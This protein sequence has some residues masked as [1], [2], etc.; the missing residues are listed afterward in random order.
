MIAAIVLVMGTIGVISWV[1]LIALITGVPV[2]AYPLRWVAAWWLR[3]PVAV[4]V[5]VLL[6]IML[7]RPAFGFARDLLAFVFPSLR[8]EPQQHWP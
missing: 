3:H 6:S 2:M 1:A 7:I 8:R 4:P 5:V